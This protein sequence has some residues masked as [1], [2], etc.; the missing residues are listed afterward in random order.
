MN[1]KVEENMEEVQHLFLGDDEEITTEETE[2][3]NE[4]NIDT[5]NE[6]ANDEESNENTDT[7]D[8][9]SEDAKADEKDTK[10]DEDKKP[11]VSGVSDRQKEIIKEVGILEK[12]I[13]QLE[14]QELDENEF[15]ENL[16]DI[17]TEEEQ[18]LEDDNKAAY[19]KVVD[20]KKTE[21]IE[22]HSKAKEIEDKKESINKL[23]IEDGI[24]EGLKE[25]VSIYPEYDHKE[26]A[27][28]SQME[29]TTKER[30]EIDAKATSFADVFKL[31]YEKYLEKS[32]KQ[33]PTI[34]DTKAPATPK[35]DEV[36]QTTIKDDEIDELNTEDEA[37]RDAL[38]L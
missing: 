29:L 35:P 3:S 31:T 32:G 22:K 24:E 21:W 38:G 12:E 15:Y 14:E 28:F 16:D 13:E 2:T 1:I 36:N 25:V 11:V 27:T 20:K 5:S 6:T 10:K 26:M 4:E 30:D 7:K 18:Y 23:Q 17:L 9:K 19:L 8:D 37:Y 33:N 34:K